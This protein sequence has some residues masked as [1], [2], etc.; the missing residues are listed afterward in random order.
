MRIIPR[1]DVKNEKVIKGINLEGLRVVGNPLSFAK[2][3]YDEG[4]DELIYID[5]VASLY[6]QN[7]LAEITLKSTKNIFI[8]FCV[9][10]GVRS[11]LDAEKL[12][13]NGA[14]KIAINTAGIENTG[15][16]ED[17]IKKFG[18]QSIILSVQAKKMGLNS[19]RAYKNFGR[20]DSGKDV[21]DWILEASELGVGEILLT[22]IDAEGLGEG[23]EIELYKK[24][25]RLIKTPIIASG[26]F[27]KLEHIKK[28]KEETDIDAITVSQAIHYN[29]LTL[30]EIKEYCIQNNIDV[31]N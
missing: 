30:K 8:P 24:C 11:L 27:G 21:I 15:L 6:G 10:G 16:I 3:Y 28:L 31:R 23:F 4:A 12:F 17:L 22:S 7:N 20:D 25:T 19:W 18:S 13:K 14:D 1:L 9:G 2:K 26:G 5:C 29:K